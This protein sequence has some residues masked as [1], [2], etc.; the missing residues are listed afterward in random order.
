MKKLGI[1]FIII[2]AAFSCKKD[3]SLERDIQEIGTDIT[4]E[5]FD[6]LF[7]RANIEDLNELKQ[8]Y[9]FMF[10]EKYPDSFWVTQMRDTLQQ[11]LFAEVE[12]IFPNFDAI[13]MEIESLFNHLK[14]YFSEFTPPRVITTTSM[15]DY[16]NKVILTD[17][18]A[19]LSID[20]YLG[21]DH[22]FYAGIQKFIASNLKKE[23]IV[24]DL[25]NAYAKKYIHQSQPKTLLDEMIYFGKI[26]YFNDVMIP[27]KSEAERIGYTEEELQWA[28][29]N[30]SYI[31][32]Y[33]IERE[34]LYSTDSK[35]PN[36]FINPAPFTKF[37]LEEIDNNSPARLGQYI[38]WQIVRAYMDKNRVPLR[39][40]LAKRPEDIFINSKFKPR[41]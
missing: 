25:S 34:L 12:K 7:A 16:R 33:F 24:V 1:L 31:W 18:I 38:G 41:K 15:V 17:T 39:D 32:R 23:Q 22:E 36:R 5:R 13:E 4:V 9:P 20:T 21:R 37:Y 11:Q 3:S 6:L 28:R 26:L 10:A 19:L 14:Y 8:G 30:E 35:L 27:F 29:A 2:F 40:M